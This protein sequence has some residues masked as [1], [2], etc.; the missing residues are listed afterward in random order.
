MRVSNCTH[1]VCSHTSSASPPSVGCCLTKRALIIASLSKNIQPPCPVH[2]PALAPSGS[3]GGRGPCATPTFGIKQHHYRRLPTTAMKT[4]TGVSHRS[5]P[6]FPFIYY[7][8][9]RGSS[10]RSHEARLPSYLISTTSQHA[11]L[12]AFSH[13]PSHP[14]L[15]THLA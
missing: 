11:S 5:E 6:T 1:W 9:T 12:T 13:L 3:A 14:H 8:L 4:M 7:L 2:L 15:H 10:P